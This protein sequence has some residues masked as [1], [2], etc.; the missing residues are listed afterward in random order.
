MGAVCRGAAGEALIVSPSNR[1]AR[2][3]RLTKARRHFRG[4][5][6]AI[7]DKEPRF[8]TCRYRGARAKFNS[9]GGFARA[10]WAPPRPLR[11]HSTRIDSR[12]LARPR[13][14]LPRHVIEPAISAIS[15]PVPDRRT[16]WTCRID[17]TDQVPRLALTY[18]NLF[19]LSSCDKTMIRR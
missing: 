12:P 10:N 4:P 1:V 8:R 14:H 3:S 17:L 11:A 2:F 7:S 5:R 9:A 6:L 15:N 16:S 13:R 19:L 18:P